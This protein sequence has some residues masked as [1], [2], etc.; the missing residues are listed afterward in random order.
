VP[1]LLR[2]MAREGVVVA[3]A[4]DRY[5]EAGALRRDVER[6]VDILKKEGAATPATLRDR[7]GRSRK[8]LIPLLEWCD[9][10]GITERHGDQRVLGSGVRA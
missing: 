10:Q 9:T 3:V 4:R 1:G 5:Y 2:L 7:L 8:W 6:L